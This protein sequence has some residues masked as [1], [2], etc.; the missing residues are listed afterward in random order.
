MTK[1]QFKK[2]C[3]NFWY[4]YKIHVIVAIVAILC[5][6][7]TVKQCAS[8]VEPDMTVVI[9]TKT[10]N[11]S[12]D[13]L[14]SIETMLSKYTA[15][16]NG[17]GRKVV[18]CDNYYVGDDQNPQVSYAVQAKLIANISSDKDTALYIIDSSYYS[19]LKSTGFSFYNLKQFD[20]S[21]PDSD[22]ISIKK[23]NDFNIKGLNSA[24]DK[25]TLAVR[26]FSGSTYKSDGRSGMYNN[27]ITVLK[28]LLKE[29]KK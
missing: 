15:D 1:E 19:Q 16:V 24:L 17:D 2:K 3:G 26:S 10:A 27:S 29:S 7:F 8:R 9:A 20:S 18:S 12:D 13:Q 5:V 21:A 11:L 6:A 23:L 25:Q 28:E 22:K 14:K 4:Y